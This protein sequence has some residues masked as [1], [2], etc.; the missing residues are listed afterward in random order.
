[1]ADPNSP[2]PAMIVIGVIHADESAL[3]SAI[4]KLGAVLGPLRRVGESFPFRWTDY[5]QKEMGTDLTRCFLASERLVERQWIVELKLLTN[6]IEKELAKEDGSRR[7]NLDPGL[8]SL[9]SFVLATTKN[10]GHRIYLRD[11]IFAE[12]TLMYV[13]GKFEALPWTFPDYRSEEVQGV[14]Q[15]VREECYH[16]LRGSAPEVIREVKV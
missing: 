11:G 14:L 10:R 9:E 2:D 12:V 1:M 5:Y 7:I 8:M 13:Q 3:K 6:R 16:L 4:E 15:G